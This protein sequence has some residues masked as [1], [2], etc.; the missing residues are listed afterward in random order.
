MPPTPLAAAV[1][2]AAG[3]SRRMGRPKLLLP[4]GDGT[5]LEATLAALVGGGVERA[6]VVRAPSGPL[7]AWQPPGAVTVAV[8]PRPGDGMLSTIRAGLDSL[9]AAGVL[10]NP[11]VVC[12]G[13][14]PA[15]AT[16]TVAALLAA[17][18]S[19]PRLLVPTCQGRRGHPLLVPPR[20][21]ASILELALPGGLRDILR[22]AGEEVAYLEVVDAGAVDDVDTPEA[23]EALRRA[24]PQKR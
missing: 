21:Q 1:V 5:V 18:R 9:L 2:P 7:A 14:L 20:W 23:Y 11:L 24:D 10:P 12:P 8:N 3:A 6:V 15:L 16:G 19:E 4:W 17:Y 22:L 13:D